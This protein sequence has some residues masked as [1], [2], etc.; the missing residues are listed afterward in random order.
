MTESISTD[1]I[2]VIVVAPNEEPYYL[3]MENTLERFQKAVDGYIET[4]TFAEDC[5]VVC[6]EEG[7]MNGKPD[8]FGFLGQQFLG[9]CLFVGVDGDEFADVP[10]RIEQINGLIRR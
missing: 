8:N 5:C 10:L 9:T 7:Y 3:L 4:V 2:K 1:F 6:D